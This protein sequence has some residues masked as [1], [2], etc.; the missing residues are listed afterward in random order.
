MIPAFTIVRLTFCPVSSRDDMEGPRHHVVADAAIL[1]ALD[2]EVARVPRL[3][4][5]HVRGARE[6]V[7]LQAECGD[8]EGVHD[9]R[10]L[11]EE[12]DGLPDL[13][14]ELAGRVHPRAVW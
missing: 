12:L 14:R 1:R 3:E 9:V 11:D 5:V 7:L 8:V 6:R 4:P 2:H 10:G 13:D